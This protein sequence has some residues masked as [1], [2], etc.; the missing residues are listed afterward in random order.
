MEYNI[1]S[2]FGLS[3]TTYENGCT[4]ERFAF[5]I[6]RKG[7]LPFSMRGQRSVSFGFGD[8]RHLTKFMQPM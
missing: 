4:N 1:V 3:L 6:H 2:R 5:G 7:S 8:L